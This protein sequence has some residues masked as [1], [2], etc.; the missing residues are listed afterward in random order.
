MGIIITGL[1]ITGV[2][3]GLNPVGTWG[4]EFTSRMYYRYEC[5]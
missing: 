2:F 1:L 4:P 5:S 3:S